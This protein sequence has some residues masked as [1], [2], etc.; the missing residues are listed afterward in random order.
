MIVRI[1]SMGL[2]VLMVMFF[3][4]LLVGSCQRALAGDYLPDI[5][6]ISERTGWEIEQIPANLTVIYMNG[7]RVAY[8][9]VDS[10]GFVYEETFKQQSGLWYFGPPCHSYH[11][12]VRPEPIAWRWGD[13]ED[14]MPYI[15]KTLRGLR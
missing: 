12:V 4:L 1:L 10:I 13:E 7:L 6:P 11:K 15:I 8:P 3:A 2:C 5:P 14:W 9:V